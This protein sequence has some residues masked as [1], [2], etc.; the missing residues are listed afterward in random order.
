M[1]QDEMNVKGKPL[2]GKDNNPSNILPQKLTLKSR[3]K[4]RCHPGVR[5]FTA[6]CGGIKII[7]TP[8]DILQLTKR[9]A[10]PPHEFLHQ[11]TLPTYLEKTDMPGVMIKLREEDSKCPF[12]TPAGCTV[13]SDRPTA[14]RYYPIG[15][16]SLSYKDSADTGGFYF[17]IK[18]S[19]CLGFGET[20][21]WKVADWRKDQGIEA[22]D[23]INAGWVDLVVRKRSFPAN[24]HLSEKSKSM[25]FLASYNIDKFRR[26]IF[27]SSFLSIYD[28]DPERLEAVRTDDVAMLSLAVDWLRFVLFKEGAFSID[29]AAAALRMK[30]RR[31]C[32][33]V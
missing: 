18:E 10:I 14:C 17:L 2:F 29:T 6:C 28:I 15:N 7:L 1:T 11:Y 26:F 5:C 4:F 32:A 19:H 22:H 13:Y 20:D 24:L 9:L 31:P 3:I 33:A 25:F 16:A 27:D 30:Q 8:Y 12:V 21:R 23:E